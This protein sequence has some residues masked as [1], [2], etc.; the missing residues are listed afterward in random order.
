MYKFVN[1]QRI[2]ADLP[3]DE[4]PVLLLA[5]EETQA[6]TDAVVVDLLRV[7]TDVE[8]V[9]AR[10]RMLETPRDDLLHEI[11]RM[12]SAQKTQ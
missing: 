8:A 6:G 9:A 3:T 11:D 1:G 12:H 10:L 7:M 4:C 2:L 5:S